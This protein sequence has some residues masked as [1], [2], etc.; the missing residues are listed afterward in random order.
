MKRGALIALV[1]AALL[2]SCHPFATVHNLYR[3]YCDESDEKKCLLPVTIDDGYGSRC[4]YTKEQA[5]DPGAAKQAPCVLQ[6]AA[7]SQ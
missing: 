7:L 4:T 6:T 3:A 2:L 5:D 1:A